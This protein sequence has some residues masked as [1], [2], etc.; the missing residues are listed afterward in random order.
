MTTEGPPLE[1]LLRRLAETPQD[2]LAAPVIG[3]RGSVHTAAVVN[4]LLRMHGAADVEGQVSEL[5]T[6]QDANRLRLALVLSWLMGD[7]T[8]IA[9]GRKSR[10]VLG[11]IL[12]GSRELAP[13]V[14]AA[15]AVENAERREEVARTVL[16]GLSLRPLGESEP[17]ARDR[18]TTL[19]TAERSRVL[20]ASR[21]AEARARAIREALAKKAAEESA[22]KWSR[23]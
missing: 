16:A 20:A 15:K 2:F 13:F 1:I 10:E 11:V 8:I 6:V 4:D 14:P 3:N 17:F 9:L 18:L 22:D 12:S 5:A 21:E 19:S 23:E 7:E